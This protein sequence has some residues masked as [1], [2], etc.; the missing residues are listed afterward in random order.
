MY[1]SPAYIHMHEVSRLGT[2]DCSLPAVGSWDDEKAG[3]KN[4]KANGR[5]GKNAG[6]AR[7]AVVLQSFYILVRHIPVLHFKRPSTTSLMIH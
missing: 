6:T 5:A 3:L 1:L 7:K 2:G 4:D